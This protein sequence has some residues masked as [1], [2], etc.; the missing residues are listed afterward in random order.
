MPTL[1]LPAI[2]GSVHPREHGDIVLA[3]AHISPPATGPDPSKGR[4]CRLADVRA[5]HPPD[6][7]PTVALERINITLNFSRQ[8]RALNMKALYRPEK[9]SLYNH[10]ATN[11]HSSDLQQGDRIQP[12]DIHGTFS[13][14]DMDMDRRSLSQQACTDDDEMLENFSSGTSVRSILTHVEKDAT[15]NFQSRDF[16]MG[17][18]A[19]NNLGL[20]SQYTLADIDF[21][22]L[23]EL[24]DAALRTLISVDPVR[25]SPGIRLVPESPGLKLAQICPALFSPGYLI[26]R[27]E[28]PL[29]Y[30]LSAQPLAD[31]SGYRRFPNGPLLS[32][33][34][35]IP[36]VL[37][38]VECY[39][40][41]CD[42]S[43]RS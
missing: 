18:A 3:L 7:V 20:E 40:L 28:L 16:G 39:P 34:F 43:L 32:R 33:I 25:T 36:W 31:F 35:R 11:E 42:Q 13:S 9:G 17:L 2:S 30:T 23:L 22:Q 4:K 24:T 26:V 6:G 27:Y 41:I 21:S 8:T 29:Q 37:S 38:H 19:G 5:A 15:S 12:M 10:L 14:V 1:S